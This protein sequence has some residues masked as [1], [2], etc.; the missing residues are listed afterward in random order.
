MLKSGLFYPE[1]VIQDTT[2]SPKRSSMS[3]TD[4]HLRKSVSKILDSP[5]ANIMVYPTLLKTKSK[6]LQ[7]VILRLERLDEDRKNEASIIS[8][9]SPFHQ[10]SNDL[11]GHQKSNFWFIYDE[12]SLGLTAG[13]NRK[14]ELEEHRKL[15]AGKMWNAGLDQQEDVYL[16]RLIA[17]RTELEKEGIIA[18]KL[19]NNMII[20]VNVTIKILEK[21]QRSS[22]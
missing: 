13:F 15:V 10:G 12:D 16:K 14:G 17:K 4:S 9:P 2:V 7:Y 22:D 5:I 11:Q 21:R 20:S 8:T 19:H 6:N 1:I 18:M 3:P